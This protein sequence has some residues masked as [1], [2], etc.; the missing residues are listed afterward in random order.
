MSPKITST[1][2]KSQK[3]DVRLF[4]GTHASPFDPVLLMPFVGEA[5][6]AAVKIAASLGDRPA[7]INPVMER[8]PDEHEFFVLEVGASLSHLL[9]TCEHLRACPVF[10][11]NYRS[12]PALAKAGLRRHTHAVFQVESYLVRVHGLLDRVLKLINAVFHLCNSARNCTENVILKNI[13]VQHHVDVG[14]AVKRFK[15]ALGPY[16]SERNEVVHAKHYMEQRLRYAEMFDLMA[17]AKELDGDPSAKDYAKDSDE[18]VRELVQEKKTEFE[19]F[20]VELA[21]HLK[22]ILEA[23]APCYKIEEAAL[24]LR[25]EKPVEVLLPE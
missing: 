13:K 8:D 15:K 23:L 11:A 21:S 6:A 19:A 25:L 24:R 5:G 2:A 9:T 17:R 20:N 18:L 10:L 1:E 22:E 14:L 12:T 3:I 4:D 16:T 7:L